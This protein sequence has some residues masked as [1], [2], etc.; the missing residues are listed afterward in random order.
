MRKDFLKKY[1]WDV[2]FSS[3]DLKKYKRYV[4]E[5]ILSLGDLEAVRWMMKNFNR[6]DVRSVAANSRRLST[7]TRNFWKL[8]LE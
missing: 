1:F 4:I 7:K 5:R 8:I 3:L 2:D 6:R